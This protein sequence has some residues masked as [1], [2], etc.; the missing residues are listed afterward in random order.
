MFCS[1]C[2]T[3]NPDGAA[4]CRAC[5]AP[6]R[7][8]RPEPKPQ[9]PKPH[10]ITEPAAVPEAAKSSESNA[11]GQAPAPTESGG[12]PE[13]ATST[14]KIFKEAPGKDPDFSTKAAS[15]PT[16]AGDSASS[17]GTQEPVHMPS[18]SPASPDAHAAD[19]KIASPVRTP[20]PPQ[21]APTS[22]GGQ[23][24]PDS[25]QQ[26]R[27]YRRIGI[28]AVSAV[29]LVAVAGI[30]ALC[31][32][33]FG[34]TSYQRAI[35]NLMQ[36]SLGA[37][38]KAAYNMFPKAYQQKMLDEQGY[39]NE[40]EAIEDISDELD[41]AKAALDEML[42]EGWQYNYKVLSAENRSGREL[43]ELKEEYLD[44]YDIQV[45]AAMT[46]EVELAIRCD[47][48]NQ[49]STMELPL[50]KIGRSWYIDFANASNI[51]SDFLR[52]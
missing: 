16:A 4:F 3:S 14:E 20:M 33:L 36:A 37:D 46:A 39:A 5:G 29:A 10:P 52:G 11:P 44:D 18:P 49:S 42:G 8:P 43:R 51:L 27:H 50:V 26:A 9:P 1:K 35:D 41:D 31:F 6:M 21:A 15:S 22:G 25:A 32:F 19:S 30:I 28:A 17:Q 40:R 38:A 2:G 23:K 45:D 13:P 34:G 12:H 48:G 47:K 24:P 7:G